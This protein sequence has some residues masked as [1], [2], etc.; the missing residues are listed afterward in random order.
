MAPR[1][2][3]PLEPQ[4]PERKTA[5]T[6]THGHSPEVIREFM[7]LWRKGVKINEIADKLKIGRST[8]FHWQRNCLKTGGV[9]VPKNKPVG[10]PNVM[11]I[12]DEKALRNMLLEKGWIDQKDMV[13]W[14]KENR[15]VKI[16]QATISR[17]LTRN[18]WTPA[19]FKAA[20]ADPPTSNPDTLNDVLE[21]IEGSSQPIQADECLQ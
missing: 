3:L 16:S 4:R 8:A 19:V 15:G 14:L 13:V 21:P 7:E 2:S 6:K 5:A 11:T 17:L 20:A 1:K 18:G 9:V 12:E 10:R